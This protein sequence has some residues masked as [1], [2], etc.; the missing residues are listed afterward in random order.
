MSGGEFK[1]RIFELQSYDVKDKF[2]NGIITVS[3]TETYKIIDEARKDFP[4]A[5][6]SDNLLKVEDCRKLLAKRHE[7]LSKW[8][9][10]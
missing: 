2:G 10:E 4:M 3:L 9:G 1:K 6:Y 7:W 8:F 5:T